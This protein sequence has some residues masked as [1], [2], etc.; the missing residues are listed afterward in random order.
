MLQIRFGVTICVFTVC[1]KDISQSENEWSHQ[2]RKVE[3]LSEGTESKHAVDELKLYGDQTREGSCD[4]SRPLGQLSCTVCMTEKCIRNPH[5]IQCAC[6]AS[7]LLLVP[8]LQGKRESARV[9]CFTSW[10]R[11]NSPHSHRPS[12]EGRDSS[13]AEAA[14]KPQLTLGHTQ[15]LAYFFFSLC[16]YLVFWPTW[17]ASLLS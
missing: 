4:R 14:A 9:Q 16:T 2:L 8:C 11:P 12:A 1:L 13:H 6:V 7:L 17:V 15:K 5:P 3:G 10:S